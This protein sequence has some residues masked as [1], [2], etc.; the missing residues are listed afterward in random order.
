MT[1]PIEVGS[2]I[3]GK[4]EFRARDIH[5]SR[6]NSQVWWKS[7]RGSMLCRSRKHKTGTADGVFGR[8]WTMLS[9]KAVILVLATAKVEESENLRYLGPAY[10]EYRERTKMFIPFPF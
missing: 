3:R 1:G 9:F 8:G 5:T 6:W 4:G 7:G 2:T 10:A